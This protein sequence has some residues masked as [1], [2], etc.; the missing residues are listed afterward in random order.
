M[1]DIGQLFAI[2]C[3]GKISQRIEAAQS[4]FGTKPIIV[5]VVLKHA[6][7]TA[8]RQSTFLGYMTD[9]LFVADLI[10]TVRHTRNPDVILPVAVQVVY[11]LVCEFR[12]RLCNRMGFDIY[13]VIPLTCPGKQ[14][15]FVPKEEFYHK[16]IFH[17]G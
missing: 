7:G 14:R 10:H 9:Y 17:F 5:L 13:F 1:R 12:E 4:A 11:L 16:N 2:V 6:H 15:V 3:I 8:C